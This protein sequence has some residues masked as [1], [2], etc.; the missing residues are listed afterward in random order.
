MQKQYDKDKNYTL[1]SSVL[2][3]MCSWYGAAKRG[4][5]LSINSKIAWLTD[6][7]QM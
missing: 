3:A 6:D 1:T 2:A 7:Q 4:Q 5:V